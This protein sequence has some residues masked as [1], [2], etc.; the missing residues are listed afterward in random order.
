MAQVQRIDVPPTIAAAESLDYASAFAL[1]FSGSGAKPR[2][3][4]QWTRAVFEGAPALLRSCI[5]F[6]WRFV[7]G[8]R[9]RP[10]AADHV[11]GWSVTASAPEPD[12][13]TLAADSRLLSAE[14]IVAADDAVVVWVTVVRYESRLARPLWVVASKV[15]HLTIRFLLGR[16]ARGSSAEARS[17]FV[18][19]G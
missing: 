9:L 11:L 10:E 8:L 4:E 17:V 19:P 1:T 3:A 7:L 18:A 15:H 5:L 16:A 6:G 2:S 12:T 14:N 13:V